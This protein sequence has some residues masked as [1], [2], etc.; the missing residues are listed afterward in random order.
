MNT[1]SNPVR[2]REDN[3]LL[4]FLFKKNFC[5]KWSDEYTKG[6]I[7]NLEL[8]VSPYCNLGCTYCYIHRHGKKLMPQGVNRDNVLKNTELIADWLIENRY[9]PERIEIFSGELFAQELGYEVLDILYN[10]FKEGIKFYKRKPVFVIPTNFSFLLDGDLTKRVED[11]I[12]KFKDIGMRISLSA[13]L[14]GKYLEDENRPIIGNLDYK[15][16]DKKRD[17]EFYNRAFAFAK[18]YGYG[19]HPMIYSEGI[20]KW[21]DNFLWFMDMFKK[22]DIPITRLFLLQVRNMEWTPKQNA[23]LVKFIRFLFKWVNDYFKGDKEK[24]VNFIHSDGFN[25]M[26]STVGV[27]HKGLPCS[28]QTDPAIRLEDL[29]L[30]PCHRLMYDGFEFGE[31]EVKNGKLTGNLIAKNTE[32]YIAIIGG[33]YATYPYCV[34]CGIKHSCTG[35][36]L[37]A[38]LEVTGDPFLPIPSMC[39]MQH[40]IMVGIILGTLDIGIYPE[41]LYYASPEQKL[42]H[43]LIRKNLEELGGII[44]EF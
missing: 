6:D 26:R 13:S 32:M 31:F 20:E 24:I 2:Q 39:A 14:D 41:Y 16:V 37:G 15:F 4:N 33:G 5:E 12:N 9:A 25:I 30:V 1:F 11:I 35:G 36:C 28:I 43:E 18:K 8:I 17:D 29:R 27:Y 10:K 3:E 7:M 44:Y 23:E 22:Y 40:A 21:K 34:T 19:F 38:Q 42:E